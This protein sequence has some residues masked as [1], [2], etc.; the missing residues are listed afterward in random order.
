[1]FCYRFLASGDRVASIA[2]SDRVSYSKT[3]SIIQETCEDL[4]QTLKAKYIPKPTAEN[5]IENA[6]GFYERWNF[7]N[8]VAAIDGKHIKLRAPKNSGSLYRNYKKSFSIVLMA[9][10][11]HDYKFTFVD[12]GDY[13]SNN[14]ASVFNTSVFG[15]KFNQGQLFIPEED[16]P[17]GLSELR[18]KYFFI[19][20]GAF[21]LS[22]RMMKPYGGTGLTERE[23]IYNYRISRA[24]RMIESTFGLLTARFRIFEN[25]IR[26]EPAHADN[27][28]MAAC[29][30]HNFLRV[31]GDNLPNF[32][33][34]E[35]LNY[36]PPQ[37]ENNQEQAQQ[38]QVNASR[39]AALAQRQRKVLEE[40]FLSPAGEI[41]YQY[42]Y[43]RRGFNAH[44]PPQA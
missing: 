3:L 27:I 19:G 28:V 43:V 40:Y 13:G 44:D 5:W 18:T 14:D 32:D 20:D 39:E 42:A 4:G 35:D 22:R 41:P 26:M 21:Q 12:I 36:I 33:P 25:S 30:L 6:N 17:L 34:D 7:P 29:C 9:A 15:Q 23:R 2:R 37:Q 31:V 10:C 8:C 11:D 38:I 16:V 24:R 1:M